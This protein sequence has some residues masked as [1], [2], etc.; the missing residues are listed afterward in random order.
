MSFGWP[1]SARRDV[2]GGSPPR[3]YHR[4]AALLDGNLRAFLHRSRALRRSV[5]IF[6]GLI[7]RRPSVRLNL[8][9]QLWR[10]EDLEGVENLPAEQPSLMSDIEQNA[11]RLKEG[12][13]PRYSD[14]RWRHRLL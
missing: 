10:D 7:P 4:L 14:W 13:S 12:T 8:P 11:S 9:A 6:D 5:A 2:E 3:V 1:P